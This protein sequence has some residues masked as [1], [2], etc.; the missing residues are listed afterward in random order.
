MKTKLKPIG[1]RILVEPART[2]EK[3]SGGILIPDCAKEKPQECVVVAVGAGRLDDSGNHIPIEVRIGDRV[4]VTKYG[5]TEVKID[6]KD[7]RVVESSDII[8]VLN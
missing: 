7:H 6:G 4:L 5:G 8:G 2:E 1:D 3:S